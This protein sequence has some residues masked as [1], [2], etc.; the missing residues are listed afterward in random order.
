MSKADY[1]TMQTTRIQVKIREGQARRQAEI[2]QWTTRLGAARTFLQNTKRDRDQ[3]RWSLGVERPS[4][5]TKEAGELKKQIEYRLDRI[6]D[7]ILA[8]E[9]DIIVFTDKIEQLGAKVPAKKRTLFEDSDSDTDGES[10]KEENKGAGR[11]RKKKQR[12]R[13]VPKKSSVEKPSVERL[14]ATF[15]THAEITLET[16]PAVATLTTAKPPAVMKKKRRSRARKKTGLSTG[17]T[18][19]SLKSSNLIF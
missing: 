7:K 5:T 9:A 18:E 11:F 17:K 6:E 4:L 14:T 1:A 8:Y 3:I 19:A 15:G 13:A 10:D 12:K 16:P 2:N